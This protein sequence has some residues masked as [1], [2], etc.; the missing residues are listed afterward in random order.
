MWDQGVCDPTKASACLI[1]DPT[2]LRVRQVLNRLIFL[3]VRIIKLF[4]MHLTYVFI[5]LVS[6]LND[7]YVCYHA[8]DLILTDEDESQAE[9][10]VIKENIPMNL[11]E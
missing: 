9:H 6:M 1:Y 3:R 8:K 10:E 5:R 2:K 4:R 11:I 7:A